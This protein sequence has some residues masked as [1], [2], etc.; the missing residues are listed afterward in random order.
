MK[1]IKLLSHMSNVVFLQGGGLYAAKRFEA[2]TGL[3][4]FVASGTLCG[5]VD[6]VVPLDECCRQTRFPRLLPC[7]E[8]L[9]RTCWGIRDHS[10]IR[11]CTGEG[12]SLPA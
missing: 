11:G 9:A 7:S 2:R 12:R 3:G 6:F 8:M 10:M 4:E 1:T 5:H